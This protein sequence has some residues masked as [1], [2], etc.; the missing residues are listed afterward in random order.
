VFSAL[1]TSILHAFSGKSY[2]GGSGYIGWYALGMPLLAAVVMLS[3]TQQS[4]ADLKLLWVLI[5]G[6]LIKPVLIFFFHS[7]LLVVSLMSDLAIAAVLVALA[8]QYLLTER[9]QRLLPS[10]GGASHDDIDGNQGLMANAPA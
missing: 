2:E 4:L 1:S 3:N 10:P 5:P 9:R 6:T 8:V 7:S